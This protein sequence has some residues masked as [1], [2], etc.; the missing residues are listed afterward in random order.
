VR[1]VLVLTGERPLHFTKP[2]ARRWVSSDD[3]EWQGQGHK[4]IRLTQKGRVRC[5]E[6][7]AVLKV[8]GFSAV[9]GETIALSKEPWARAFVSQQLG[10]QKGRT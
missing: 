7:K 9:V 1:N 5:H 10:A 8:R 4:R 6:I 3:A 2:E